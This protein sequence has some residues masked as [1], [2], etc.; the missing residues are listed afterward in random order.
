MDDPVRNVLGNRRAVI[1][2]ASGTRIAH[3]DRSDGRGAMDDACV[4]T[5]GCVGDCDSEGPTFGARGGT[6]L[7]RE[8][9][10]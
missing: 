7:S 10:T 5:V 3:S 2:L 1:V 6:G 9:R 8:T 4:N